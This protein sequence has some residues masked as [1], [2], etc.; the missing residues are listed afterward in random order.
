MT[1]HNPFIDQLCFLPPINDFNL[2]AKLFLYTINELIG[3][4]GLTDS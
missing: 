3:I 1:Q 4:T 2:S